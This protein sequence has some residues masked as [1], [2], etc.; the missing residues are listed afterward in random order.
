MNRE[1]AHAAG[2][3]EWVSAEITGFHSGRSSERSFGFSYWALVDGSRQP[4]TLK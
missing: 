4:I 3:T 1:T 2:R